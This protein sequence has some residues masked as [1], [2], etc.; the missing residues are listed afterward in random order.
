MDMLKFVKSIVEQGG[1]VLPKRLVDYYKGAYN[2]SS[3]SDFDITERG[4]FIGR[5]SFAFIDRPY[6]EFELKL[7]SNISYSRNKTAKNYWAGETT[8]FN[9]HINGASV[10]TNYMLVKEKY[11]D[12]IALGKK[13]YNIDYPDTPEAKLA[14]LK[15]RGGRPFTKKLQAVYRK[16]KKEA[17]A[18]VEDFMKSFYKRYPYMVEYDRR[19]SKM[20]GPERFHY[21]MRDTALL[22]EMGLKFNNGEKY[23][24]HMFDRITK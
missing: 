22:D 14:M 16:R 19:W 4:A 12:F 10:Y 8:V 23:S 5:V 17:V 3:V 13:Y 21:L 18:I 11:L 24:I 9:A 7:M 2:P 20:T 6:V 15:R 1:Y